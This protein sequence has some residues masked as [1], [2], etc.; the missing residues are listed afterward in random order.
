MIDTERTPANSEH[1]LSILRGL[2][3]MESMLILHLF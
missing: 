3:K 2:T 1:L